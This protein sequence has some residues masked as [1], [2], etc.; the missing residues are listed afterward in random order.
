MDINSKYCT[1]IRN[2]NKQLRIRIRTIT[3][4]AAV[5]ALICGFLLFKVFN[6]ELAIRNYK[7]MV[8]EHEQVNKTLID[9]NIE[10]RNNLDNVTIEIKERLKTLGIVLDVSSVVYLESAGQGEQGMQY[11]ADCIVNRVESSQFSATT[12]LRSAISSAKQFNVLKSMY[13][14]TPQ[15]R[16]S[17]TYQ[18]ALDIVSDTILNGSTSEVLFFMNP[19]YSNGA[20]VSWFRN[21]KTFL[22]KYKDHEFY[23]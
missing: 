17:V 21:E 9:Q 11:V 6:K 22:F 23:K 8:F 2:R 15:V 20:S 18:R 13:K 12:S 19:D 4:F 3:I 5:L 1:Y 14:I 16:E 7:Q 10:L